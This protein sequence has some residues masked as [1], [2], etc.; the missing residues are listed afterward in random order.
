MTEV[1]MLTCESLMHSELG[2]LG[3]HASSGSNGTGTKCR[4]ELRCDKRAADSGI[5]VNAFH[6]N[7]AV[8]TNRGRL[9]LG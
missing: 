5:T 9:G 3:L 4:S 2:Q 8:R 1:H 6:Q 7:R